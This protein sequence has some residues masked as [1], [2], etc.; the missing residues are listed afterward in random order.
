[1]PGIEERLHSR[2]EWGLIADLE[3]PDLETK[4]AILKR[5]ADDQGIDLPDDVALFLASASKHNIRELEGSLV[6]LLAIASMRAVPVTITLAEEALGKISRRDQHNGISI[7]R[8]QDVVAAQYKLK[9]DNLIS[10]SNVRQILLPR[11]VAMYLCRQ[12]IGS[13]YPEIGREFGGKHHTTVIHSVEKIDR[14]ISADIELR[15]TLNRITHI[16]KNSIS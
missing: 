1:M 3:L 13:S 5:K 16:L 9:V 7:R 6:R 2:F 14:L 4:V 8:V 15:N 10:R 11:Q 12:L